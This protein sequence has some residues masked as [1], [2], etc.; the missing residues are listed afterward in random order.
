VS[1]SIFQ[2]KMF[3]LF[4]SPQGMALEPFIPSVF[5]FVY[6][7]GVTSVGLNGNDLYLRI[8]CH[9]IA[10]PITYIFL[11]MLFSAG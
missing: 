9:I 5:T 11:N 2:L 3:I 1:S 10:C 4:L 7:I 8:L 6:C